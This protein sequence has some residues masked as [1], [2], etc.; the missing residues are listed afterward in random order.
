MPWGC[1]CILEKINGL[2]GQRLRASRS[3]SPRRVDCC[4][5]S[6]DLMLV[7]FRVDLNRTESC[8]KG[9][10]YDMLYTDRC[11]ST[12]TVRHLTVTPRH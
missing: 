1:D 12:G 9:M 2:Y 4:L 7:S 3:L 5:V 11:S 10:F 6:S 8:K